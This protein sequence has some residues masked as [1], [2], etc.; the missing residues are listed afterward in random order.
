[1]NSTP[2]PRS[3]PPRSRVPAVPTRA[4]LISLTA[5]L[6]LRPWTRPRDSGARRHPQMSLFANA[7]TVPCLPSASPLPLALEIDAPAEDTPDTAPPHPQTA[8][9]RRLASSFAREGGAN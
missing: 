2:L 9:S 4:T 8:G 1:M 5:Q 6:T 7:L 3:S